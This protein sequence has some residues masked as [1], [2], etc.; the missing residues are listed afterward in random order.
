LHK[1]QR[2]VDAHAPDV[3]HLS[4]KDAEDRLLPQKSKAFPHMG[5]IFSLITEKNPHYQ[6]FTF[7]LEPCYTN[8]Q[9]HGGARKSV[10]YLRRKK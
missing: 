5:N 10:F 6:M 1:Q 3:A 8:S 4:T 9:H 7:W 2:I